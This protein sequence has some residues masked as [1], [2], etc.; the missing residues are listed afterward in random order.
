MTLLLSCHEIIPPQGGYAWRKDEAFLNTGM[1]TFAG[2]VDLVSEKSV[3]LGCAIND[4]QDNC[5]VATGFGFS[6]LVCKVTATGKDF[7]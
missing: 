6:G 1:E 2:C 4:W 5:P 3:E 7:P